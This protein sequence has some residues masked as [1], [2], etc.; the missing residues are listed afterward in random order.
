MIARRL[1]LGGLLTAAAGPAIVRAS[2]LMRVKPIWEVEVGI[3]E[4]TRIIPT[5]NPRGFATAADYLNELARSK[6][7]EWMQRYMD[8][9]M[10]AH[11]TGGAV[12]HRISFDVPQAI[13]G[14]DKVTINTTYRL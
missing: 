10:A 2:S 3:F 5:P 8:A 12:L 6:A 4:P 13:Q 1:F 14:H 9:S 7:E 11:V